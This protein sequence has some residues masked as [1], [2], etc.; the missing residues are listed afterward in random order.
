M[1]FLGPA[2]SISTHTRTHTNGAICNNNAYETQ[3][4]TNLTSSEP[5]HN[6]YH[7]HYDDNETRN[8]E[9]INR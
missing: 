6:N 4:Q 9:R 5:A 8:N 2:A 3:F 1:N 7:H